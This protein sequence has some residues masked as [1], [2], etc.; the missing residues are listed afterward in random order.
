[1]GRSLSLEFLDA[2]KSHYCLGLHPFFSYMQL[3]LPYPD[4]LLLHHLLDG[5]TIVKVRVRAGS[6][7]SGLAQMNQRIL[8]ELEQ[9]GLK[10]NVCLQRPF[11]TFILTRSIWWPTLERRS[12]PSIIT[13]RPCSHCHTKL[14]SS[15]REKGSQRHAALASVRRAISPWRLRRS[16]LTW[17]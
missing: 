6:D 14:A 3:L 11:F 17:Q 10:P 2:R 7:L 4:H 8:G 16:D 13:G 5:T 12:G 9:C 15:S 1:M